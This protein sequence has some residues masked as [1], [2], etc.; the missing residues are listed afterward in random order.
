MPTGAPQFGVRFIQCETAAQLRGS[1]GARP[2]RP[3]PFGAREAASV[4]L[5]GQVDSAGAFRRAGERGPGDAG[6]EWSAYR[7]YTFILLKSFQR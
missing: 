2:G 3:A 6:R 4:L 5:L 1:P 7:F